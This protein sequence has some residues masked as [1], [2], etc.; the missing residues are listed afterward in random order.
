MHSGKSCAV[1]LFAQ[2]LVAYVEMGFFISVAGGI[3][4]EKDGEALRAAVSRDRWLRIV[5]TD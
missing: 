1:C 3:C 2:E 4:R 5:L